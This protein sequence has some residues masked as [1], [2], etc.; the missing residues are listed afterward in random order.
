[1]AEGLIFGLEQILG[2]YGGRTDKTILFLPCDIPL[3]KSEE[4]D[5]LLDA[6]WKL[7]ADFVFTS[8]RLNALNGLKQR[9]TVFSP[10]LGAR[11]ASQ[12]VNFLS[13]RCMELDNFSRLVCLDRQGQTINGIGE[14]LDRM[15]RQRRSVL[16]WP[17]LIFQFY[18]IRM[19][20]NGHPLV[21]IESFARL[22]IGRLTMTSVRKAYAASLKIKV[23]AI[24]SAFPSF[25][26]DV[27]NPGDFAMIEAMFAAEASW[28]R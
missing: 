10:E 22:L 21:M 2:Q 1:M 4:I 13:G 11:T 23:D 28:G 6:Y 16:L 26:F 15:R 17:R 3:V 24:I 25:S 9:L 18:I 12:N 14:I 19:L 7:D 27:D 5:T 20:K 8:I